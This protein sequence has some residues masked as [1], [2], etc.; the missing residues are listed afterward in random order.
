VVHPVSSTFA[1]PR[2]RWKDNKSNV[3]FVL[4]TGLVWFNVGSCD[5]GDELPGYVKTWELPAWLRK[6]VFQEGLS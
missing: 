2:L 1:R 5:R 6:S 4:W 3:D